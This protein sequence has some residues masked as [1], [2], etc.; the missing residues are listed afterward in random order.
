MHVSGWLTSG[1]RVGGELGSD[2]NG[3]GYG[4]MEVSLLG[5]G[6]DGA[7]VFDWVILVRVVGSGRKRLAFSRA[8]R[9]IAAGVGGDN[10]AI[11]HASESGEF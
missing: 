11:A 10:V 1:V 3:M 6:P 4:A 5:S 2:L 7:G 8:C 9:D